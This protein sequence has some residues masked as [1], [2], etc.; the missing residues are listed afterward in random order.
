MDF[1]VNE[2]L[3]IRSTWAREQ[4]GA[5]LHILDGRRDELGCADDVDRAEEVRETEH[6]TSD[7]R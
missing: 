1:D 2:N 6:Q 4:A 5:E 7:P 3:C